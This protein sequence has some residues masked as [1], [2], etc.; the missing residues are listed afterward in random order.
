[1]EIYAGNINDYTIKYLSSKVSGS[2]VETAMKYRMEADRKRSLL[3][4]ALLNHAVS[5]HYPDIS[6]PVSPSVDTYGKPHIY[7][8]KNKDLCISDD[9]SDE[10][11]FSL[12]HSGDHAVCAIGDSYTGVDIERTDD[13]KEGIAQRFFA[14]SELSYITD[15]ASFYRIW[16]L[17]ESFLKAVGLGL[18]LPLDSFSVC[19][20]N[21]ETGT[22]RFVPCTVP[23]HEGADEKKCRPFID[24]SDGYYRIY[25]M[26]INEI[27]GY[28]FSCAEY[29]ENPES[30]TKPKLIYPVL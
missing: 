1:M 27:P 22:C 4:H 11:F 14:G 8:G 23:D 26:T 16:T 7:I 30:I 28:S 9:T 15:N 24:P 10:L 20:L 29:T 13:M 19:D 25:G 3:A 2:R 17:K 12:S 18:R 5:L 6:L 21:E